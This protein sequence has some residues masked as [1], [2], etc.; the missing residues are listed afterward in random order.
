MAELD[1]GNTV[2]LQELMVST[3][4]MTDA[5]AS[6]SLRR[7]SSHRL[8]SPRSCWRSVTV[9]QRILTRQLNEWSSP[10]L[11]PA[12]CGARLPFPF[13]RESL[14]ATESIISLPSKRWRARMSCTHLRTTF[15][16]L[17]ATAGLK[18]SARPRPAASPRKLPRFNWSSIS[19]SLPVTCLYQ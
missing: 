11:V 8:S 16:S 4:A 12:I 9:Y 10:E 5:L 19:A 15:T 6:W 2:T 18:I 17:P 13:Y 14:N 1:K 3:L 7:A